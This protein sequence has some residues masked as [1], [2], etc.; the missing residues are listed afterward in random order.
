M[1]I[2]ERQL[3][4]GKNEHFVK[5]PPYYNFLFNALTSLNLGILYLN[6]LITFIEY[7]PL[8]CILL[9]T[10]SFITININYLLTRK[11]YRKIKTIAE[12]DYSVRARRVGRGG[13]IKGS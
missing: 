11:F 2:K 12:K 10:L 7:S 4:F 6:A 9:L 13:E 5:I 1:E 3:V 8:Y